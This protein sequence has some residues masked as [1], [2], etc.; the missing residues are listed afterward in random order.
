ME[1]L[2]RLGI[3]IANHPSLMDVLAAFPAAV[4][5]YARKHGGRTDLGE[6]AQMAAV[7]RALSREPEWGRN[8]PT[9]TVLRLQP[10]RFSTAP[11]PR[12]ERSEACG[13]R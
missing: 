10:L 7:E 2:R 6:M 11:P 4:D 8:G 3:G 12:P 13:G 1:D 5:A 9:L